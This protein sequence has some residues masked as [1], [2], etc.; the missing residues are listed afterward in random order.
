[1]KGKKSIFKKVL[2]VL[3]IV[4]VLGFAIDLVITEVYSHKIPHRYASAKE[5]REL[6]LSND[7]YFNNCSQNDLDYRMQKTGAGSTKSATG[8]AGRS[9][10]FAKRV[11]RYSRFQS[12]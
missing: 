4:L 3:L 8:F 7:E 12:E 11:A 6:M 1:M 2:L 10:A 5:G 9:A